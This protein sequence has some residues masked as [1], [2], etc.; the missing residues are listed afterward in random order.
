MISRSNVV[1]LV[2]WSTIIK[3][4]W[5]GTMYIMNMTVYTDHHYNNFAFEHK[6]SQTAHHRR[7]RLIW[8]LMMCECEWNAVPHCVFQIRIFPAFVLHFGFLLCPHTCP[9]HLRN[10]FKDFSFVNWSKQTKKTWGFLIR[11]PSLT[12]YP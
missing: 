3:N 12:T 1:W 4:V 9:L 11:K 5:H 6:R 8:F 10:I 7:R 2:F